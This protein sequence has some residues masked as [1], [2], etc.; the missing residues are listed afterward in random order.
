MAHGSED[1]YRADAQLASMLTKLDS[2]IVQL[3]LVVGG[4]N[5]GSNL[6]NKLD[7]L[8]GKADGKLDVSK[9]TA[10]ATGL[11]ANLGILDTDLKT[12]SDLI[13]ALGALDGT[14]DGVITLAELNSAQCEMLAKLTGIDTSVTTGGDL[15]DK[16]D[17]LDGTMDGRLTLTQLNDEALVIS[18]PKYGAVKC[19]TSYLDIRAGELETLVTITD[20]GIIYG[21]YVLLDY[22]STQQQSF[23]TLVIDGQPTVSNS[24]ESLVK[25]GLNRHRSSI[26]NILTYDDINFIYSVGLAHDI[27]FESTVLLQYK[28]N[29]GTTPRAYYGLIYATI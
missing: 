11:L 15:I 10:D 25:Y 7:A 14:M 3:M 16:L 5:T 13:D 4:L 29:H 23:V 12:G 2:S 17:A 19:D 21:G 20:R 24:F 6:L 28:E 18:R 26:V 1:Y 27:T 8:D 9:L 22:G